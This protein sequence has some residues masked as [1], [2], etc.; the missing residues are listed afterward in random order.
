MCVK[1]DGLLRTVALIISLLSAFYLLSTQQVG[2]NR[3][4]PTISPKEYRSSVPLTDERV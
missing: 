1:M 2:Q 4:R 3:L